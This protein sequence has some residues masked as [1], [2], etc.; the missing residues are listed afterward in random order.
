MAIL[1]INFNNNNN[2]N[3]NPRKRAY[4]LIYDNVVN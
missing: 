4:N 2:N 1:L 3:K